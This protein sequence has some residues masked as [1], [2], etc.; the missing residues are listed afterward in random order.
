MNEPLLQLSSCQVLPPEKW[1]EAA[2]VMAG[3]FVD[4]A[5]YTYIFQRTPSFR[6]YILEWLFRCN[7][8]VVGRKC[9]EAIRGLLVDSPHHEEE[10]GSSASSRKKI[11]V[12]CFLWTPRA[13][14]KM[15]VWELFKAGMWQ[16]PFRCYG[17]AT[18]WRLLETV[19]K[20]DLK[21]KA[22]DQSPE[23]QLMND[24][25]VNSIKLERMAVHPD[26]QGQGIGSMC[27]RQM[28]EDEDSKGD[29]VV[30]LSTQSERN[31]RFYER[32]GFRVT[33][34][35]DMMEHSEEYKYHNWSMER[36]KTNQTGAS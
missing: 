34:E 20:F 2:K 29:Y 11:V 17:F 33:S 19:N 28:L 4:S 24:H 5:S 1:S 15:T 16:V 32:L 18:L 6:R 21:K 12:A 13:Y 27:L 9:P 25:E 23:G 31:V 22:G 30:E 8:S 35:S 14:Q 7:L 26:F 3:A 36:K 10:G